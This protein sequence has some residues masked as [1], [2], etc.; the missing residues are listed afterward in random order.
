[1]N[2][3]GN[4]WVVGCGRI[5]D[6]KSNSFVEDEATVS[7]GFYKCRMPAKGSDRAAWPQA[8]HSQPFKCNR[9]GSLCGAGVPEP[10]HT[11]R[12][13][14]Y[15]PEPRWL[16]GSLEGHH[17][18]QHSNVSLQ[19]DCNCGRNAWNTWFLLFQPLQSRKAAGRRWQ[20]C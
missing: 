5:R 12:T 13:T 2:C 18:T 14:P 10:H 8:V 16:K 1:M 6:P 19:R 11:H 15:L 7:L 4:L 20:Q 3:L 9:A 17:F